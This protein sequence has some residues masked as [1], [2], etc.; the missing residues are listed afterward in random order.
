M[1]VFGEPGESKFSSFFEKIMAANKT[2]EKLRS[3][4]RCRSLGAV[5]PQGLP[6]V[7]FQTNDPNMGKFWRVLQWKTLV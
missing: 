4:D 1:A 6:D 5:P 2:R 7:I 3:K